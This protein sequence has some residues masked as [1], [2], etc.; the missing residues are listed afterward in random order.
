MSHYPS[1]TSGYVAVNGLHM[2]YEMHGEGQPLVLLHGA[3]GTI[4]SCFA[5]LLPALA[6]TLNVIAAEFQGHGRTPDV[7]RPLSYQQMASDTAALVR[8]LD[9]EIADFVGYSMGGAVRSEEHTSEL[10][11]R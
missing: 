1:T 3:L 6:R 7:D 9:I 8:A 10:Q 11:S 5:N 4:E 2:Y